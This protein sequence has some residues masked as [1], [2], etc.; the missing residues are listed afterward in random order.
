MLFFTGMSKVYLMSKNTII[1][2]IVERGKFSASVH[3]LTKDRRKKSE[4]LP[5]SACWLSCVLFPANF[6]LMF[7]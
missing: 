3:K 7:Y 4:R 6:I 5:S 1:N 2:K